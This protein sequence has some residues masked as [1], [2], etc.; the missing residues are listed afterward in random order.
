[1]IKP[2]CDLQTVKRGKQSALG[3]PANNFLFA[4]RVPA[5]N[6]LLADGFRQIT[7]YLPEGFRQI[8]SSLFLTLLAAGIL[9]ND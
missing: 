7:S 2:A 5:N 1:M 6:F 4:G 3:V 9:S 8:T